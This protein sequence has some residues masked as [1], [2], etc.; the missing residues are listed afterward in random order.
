MAFY[1]FFG[2][3]RKFLHSERNEEFQKRVD[4]LQFQTVFCCYFLCSPYLRLKFMII[5]KCQSLH[6]GNFAFANF[7]NI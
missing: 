2:F 4:L 3:F 1:G 6:N 5:K 7:L